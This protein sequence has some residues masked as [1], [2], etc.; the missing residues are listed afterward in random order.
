MKGN[1]LVHKAIEPDDL[2][3]KGR[4]N[5]ELLIGDEGLTPRAIVQPKYDGV[6]AD[7]Q[8]DFGIGHWVA[9]SRTGEPLPSVSATILKSFEA[10]A[11]PG[12]R[13][14]GELWLPGTEHSVINGRARKQSP[15]AL[16][17][18][19][20]DSYNPT[21]ATETYDMRREF[22]FTHGKVEAVQ[23]VPVDLGTSLD[24]LYE[25]AGKL[26]RRGSSAYDGLILRDRDGFFVPG[27]GRDGETI[28]IKPRKTG[29]FRVVGTTPGVG[30]RAGG[31]GALVLDLGGGITSDVGAGLTQ[32]IIHGPSPINQIAEVE[33][34]GLT[35]EGRLREPSFKSFRFD[36]K[37]ADT[38]HKTAED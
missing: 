14:M 31:I 24:E 37:E 30:N 32:D 16:E 35:R 19:L 18:R 15:Q 4:T 13:Y 8:F 12:R 2:S 34:L 26:V 3:V 21:A 11:L 10:H 5:M 6:Y 25:L 33:Y 36:K 9:H 20:F 28:K 17:V 38:I 7:F 1:V 27:K 29:D 22:L 23:D